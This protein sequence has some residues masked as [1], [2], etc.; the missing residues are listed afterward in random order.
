MK[1]LVSLM[2]A[3]ITFSMGCVASLAARTTAPLPPAQSQ[4]LDPRGNVVLYVS[5][6]SF[7]ID[8]VDIRIWIDG[9]C[10]VS[11]HFPVKDQHYHPSFRL[12]LS[13]GSHELVARSEKG[14][15]SL[16]RTFTVSGKRWAVVS[17]WHY[18]KAHYNPTPRHFYFVIQSEPI[19]FAMMRR[20]EEGDTRG[21]EPSIA[22]ARLGQ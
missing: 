19:G 13:D 1:R 4:L 22:A 5:N 3:L 6:Q 17:F 21:T 8:L 14:G 18:P 15:T 11:D 12:R 2:A 10:V 7:A 20:S 16:T 9:E